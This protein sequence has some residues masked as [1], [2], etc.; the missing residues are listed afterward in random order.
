M[1]RTKKV[2]REEEQQQ[3]KKTKKKARKKEGFKRKCGALYHIYIRNCFLFLF[4]VMYV[5][6][7]LCLFVS[8][9]ALVLFTCIVL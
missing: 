5:E 9:S 4:C 7:R 3:Q 2:A 8:I 6:G 1:R